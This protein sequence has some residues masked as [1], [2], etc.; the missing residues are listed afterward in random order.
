MTITVTSLTLINIHTDLSLMIKSVSWQTA[1]AGGGS[2]HQTHSSLSTVNIDT[3]ILTGGQGTDAAGHGISHNLLILVIDDKVSTGGQS[4]GGTAGS[5]QMQ[6]SGARALLP[7]NTLVHCKC[8]NMVGSFNCVQMFSLGGDV[9][10]SCFA[11]LLV[12]VFYFYLGFSSNFRNGSLDCHI[13]PKMVKNIH[14][15]Q[16]VL[17]NVSMDDEFQLLTLNSNKIETLSPV[18]G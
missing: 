14:S 10:M 9:S 4:H 1:A 12:I 5:G 3:G 16:N 15:L 8:D 7:T 13:C 18:S 2:H 17:I 11:E 6:A